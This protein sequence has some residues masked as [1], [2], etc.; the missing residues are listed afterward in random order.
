MITGFVFLLFTYLIASVPTGHILATLYADVDV[1]QEGSGNIGATNVNRVLGK[2]FGIATLVGDILKGLIP[3]LLAPYAFEWFAFPGIVALTAFIGHCWPAYLEFRG[4]KGVATATG[5]LV[6]LA[7]F[8]TL[9]VA[10][11]WM[12]TFLGSKRS[13]VAAIVSTMLLPLVALWIQPD[14]VWVTILLSI[15]IFVRHR[16]NIDRIITGEEPPTTVS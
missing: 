16:S 7:P 5:V 14:I 12:V 10:A 1:T 4:G 6:G 15:G 13:S 9:L 2:R 8:V 3:V 11:C